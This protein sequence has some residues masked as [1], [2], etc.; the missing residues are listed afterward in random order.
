MIN[1]FSN[2]KRSLEG[3][4]ESIAKKI[5]KYIIKD[6][7]IC[8]YNSPGLELEEDIIKIKNFILNN[9]LKIK[10]HIHLVFYLI[11]SNEGRDIY[12]NEKEILRLLMEKNIPIFF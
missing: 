9:L 1:I 8:L 6:Y 10:N 12:E 7:N 3:K 2:S 4:G 11:N 5:I